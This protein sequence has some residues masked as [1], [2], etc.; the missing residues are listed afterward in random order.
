MKLYREVLP[1]YSWDLLKRI[2]ENDF[3]KQFYLAGGTSLAL[4]IGHRESI[5]LDFF[6][7]NEFSS[8]I[9]HTFPTKYEVIRQYDNSIEIFANKTKVML[10]YFAYP[11][12][13]DI[14][15]INNLRLA[16]PID[17]G[18]MKLLAIQGRSTKKD[19]I[20]LFFID[21]EIISLEKLLE[22]FEEH[23]PKETFNSYTSLKS[24]F[25]VSS[26]ENEPM[27]KLLKTVTWHECWELVSAKIMQHIKKM[28]S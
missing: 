25:N 4:Q 15:C 22:M 16:N 18:L 26:L 21:K 10:F 17:I 13:Q 12:L 1:K 28:I 27:P 19:I 6:S 23:Y 3:F 9:L 5:D 11:L 14:L 24:I 20:D 2:S 8:T 7:P